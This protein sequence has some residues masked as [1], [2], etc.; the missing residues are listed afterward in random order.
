MKT[1]AASRVPRPRSVEVALHGVPR[2]GWTRR[3]ASFCAGA[4]REAGA[5]S[6]ELSVL[7]CDDRR[8]TE[9]NS[10][11]RGK[12]RPTDVLSF[13]R[14]EHGR[15]AGFP[16]LGGGHLAGDIAI[17]LD[18]M[19]RN[20]REMGSTEGEEL[21]R[22]IVHGILHCAGMDHGR[23]KGRGM[24]SLQEKLLAGLAAQRIIR[25]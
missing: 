12:N 17:S 6:W 3:L 21:K 2:P 7:L 24:L 18:T 22:L 8:M 19:R 4:L 1:A 13:P 16:A 10:R 11:Y 14:D 25:E 23:G 5:G 15:G 9:L 20:A